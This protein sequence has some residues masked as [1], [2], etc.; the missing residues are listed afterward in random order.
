VLPLPIFWKSFLLWKEKITAII[1]ESVIFLITPINLLYLKTRSLQ[2][3]FWRLKA[4]NVFLQ[5]F[6]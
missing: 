6:K 4:K 5:I 3:I 2:K 1:N